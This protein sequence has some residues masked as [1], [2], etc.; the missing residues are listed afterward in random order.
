MGNYGDYEE[1]NQA[2]SGFPMHNQICTKKSE[3]ADDK[4]TG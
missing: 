3:R 1:N 4:E 2:I